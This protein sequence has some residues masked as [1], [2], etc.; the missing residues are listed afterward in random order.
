MLLPWYCHGI[1][2]LLQWYCH[3]IVKV[4]RGNNKAIPCQL[5]S[6]CLMVSKRPSLSSGH[7]GRLRGSRTSSRHTCAYKH[8]NNIITSAS[9]CTNNM[10][11]PCHCHVGAMVLPCYCHGIA[12]ILPWY[13]HVIAMLLPC[14]CHGNSIAIALQ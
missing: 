13:C 7:S 6:I 4:L 11:L 10:L 1:A 14:Y 8:R 12:M 5:A 3:D 2:L 9:A